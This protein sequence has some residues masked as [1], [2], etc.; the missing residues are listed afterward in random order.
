MFLAL[1]YYLHGY[2]I[3]S[4][5]GF[6]VERFVNLAAYKGIYLWDIKPQGAG[7]TMKVSIDGFR[8][9]KECARKTGC[10]FKIIGKQGLPF[11]MH[12]YQKRKMLVV[13]AFFFVIGLY[14]L[15]SFVWVVKIE[16]NDRIPQ[17]QLLEA[18]D[19]MGLRPGVWKR[20]VDT[21]VI[22]EKLIE[23]FG[24]ISWVSVKIQGTNAQIQIVETIPKTEIVDRR[25]PTDIIAAKDGVIVSMAVS[26]GTPLVQADDVVEK[27]DMLVGGEVIIKAGEEEL[28]KEYVHAEA[29]VK[30]KLW[31]SI[32]EE[33]DLKYTQKEYTGE[34]KDDIS[35][36]LKDTIIDFIKPNVKY[37]EYDLEKIYEKPFAIGDYKFS[38][39]LRKDRYKEYVTV[40]KTRTADEAK[41]ELEAKV[42]S[43]AKELL[44]DDSELVDI[45]TEYTQS[46]ETLKVN[47][48][49]TVI[50]RIEEQR[51][52]ENWSDTTDGTNR[53]NS[54]N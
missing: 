37:E 33:I 7:V 45:K 28:G 32:E 54:E 3:I 20:K 29:V 12:H 25:T 43:K 41:I 14:I 22:S 4:V 44:K 1:W 30:A 17:Q 51:K 38:L 36:I 2:V 18:C 19:S 46:G 26:A 47:A 21:T 49:V 53:E 11:R 48:V 5:T 27:G 50:E 10:H 34:F 35:V 23:D 40:E 9:L 39:A 16:G 31:Y 6:S 42:Q 24:D 15:S 8:M 52:M 13:G